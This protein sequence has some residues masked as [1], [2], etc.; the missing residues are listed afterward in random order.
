MKARWL[1]VV[2]LGLRWGEGCRGKT[3]VSTEER[4]GFAGPFSTSQGL[5]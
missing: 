3:S 1:L 4:P 5:G 2:M